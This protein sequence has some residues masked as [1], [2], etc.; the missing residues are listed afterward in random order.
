M[1]CRSD[2][3]TH[4][5]VSNSAP[6]LSIFPTQASSTYP[7][8]PYPLSSND[9]L[10]VSAVMS[11]SA[12]SPKRRRLSS[13]RSPS[14]SPNE[15]ASAPAYTNTHY[16]S[17]HQTQAPSG[18]AYADDDEEDG[19]RNAEADH[20]FYRGRHG[21]STEIQEEDRDQDHGPPLAHEDGD[22][23]DEDASMHTPRSRLSSTP[24]S[25]SRSRSDDDATPPPPPRL[26]TP[27]EK[28]R[29]YT[30]KHVL[31]GH[32]RGVAQAKFSPDGT[33]IASCSSDATVRIWDVRS[34]KLQHVLQGHLAGI[35]TIAWSPDSETLASGSDDKSIRLWNTGS[36]KAYPV[37]LVGHHNYV[38]S[39]AFSPKGNMLVSGSYDEAVFIWD[40]RG[41]RVMRSLPAHSDPVAG[42]DFVRDG[43]LIVSCAGDGLVRI[44]DTATG[45][46]LRTLVHED[47]SP[48]AGAKFSPN[49]RFVGAWTL[50]GCMRLWSY[51]EGRCVKTY[52]GH[53]NAKF[54]LGGC[55][56]SYGSEHDAGGEA[57]AG[58]AFV[59]SGSEDGKVVVWDITTK[60]VLQEIEAHEGVVLGL[61][62]W[63]GKS[64]E[65]G[66]K[67]LLVS[68][69]IDGL[70][71]V[72]EEGDENGFDAVE[73]LEAERVA[74]MTETN[75]VDEI[76]DVDEV[77]EMDET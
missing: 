4:T 54:S 37:P 23:D 44:W 66:G 46:C 48:V 72:W 49:G 5:T 8:A 36:G 47:R 9:H 22:D 39:I 7:H 19:R 57:A 32:R 50:D 63:R 10:F 17:T 21:G 45:Q 68:C 24:S 77:D 16:S 64:G 28:Y 58:D 59:G 38:Y 26:K 62:C 52:Q 53:V 41:A 61:D 51:V 35:S 13:S 34:G 14:S 76:D 67:G 71:K 75:G 2:I 12:R 33:K 43:T 18:Y 60:E 6:Q 40:V 55:F 29:P 70:V 74:K 15:L 65:D 1:F 30:L 25:R 42:V 27:R 20:A 73:A 56:G 69:G 11:Y 31:K 3:R